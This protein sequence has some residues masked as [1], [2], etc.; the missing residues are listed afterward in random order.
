MNAAQV[1]AAQI[2]LKDREIIE[3]NE[4][5]QRLNQLNFRGPS[6]V[7]AGARAHVSFRPTSRSIS[8]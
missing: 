1:A 5:E 2:S 4:F 6:I 7:N 3:V 8:I